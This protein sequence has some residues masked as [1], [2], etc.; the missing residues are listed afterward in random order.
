M[1]WLYKRC[2]LFVLLELYCSVFVLVLIYI[3]L[4][5]FCFCIRWLCC[6]LSIVLFLILVDNTVQALSLSC[7]ITDCSSFLL[8]IAY[9]CFIFHAWSWI[10]E[11]ILVWWSDVVEAEGDWHYSLLPSG[12]FRTWGKTL[13]Q[14]LIGSNVVWIPFSNQCLIACNKRVMLV[15]WWFSPTW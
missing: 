9:T 15:A 12:C 7:L 5:F 8:N 6:F 10:H 11:S 2:S 3:V 13:F 1:A 14:R 4:F